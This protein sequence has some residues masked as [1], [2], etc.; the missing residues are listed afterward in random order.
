MK[1]LMMTFALMVTAGAA[2]AAAVSNQAQ[3]SRCPS[4]IQFGEGAIARMQQTRCHQQQ[5]QHNRSQ[6]APREVRSQ[7]PAPAQQRA[8]SAISQL[9]TMLNFGSS[10]R[11]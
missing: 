4:A 3:T 2:S 11:Y 7:Q 8:P 6:A 1:A 9:Q 10:P 5:Q